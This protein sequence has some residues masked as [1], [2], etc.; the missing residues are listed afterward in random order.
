MAVCHSRGGNGGTAL[1]SA[2]RSYRS[3]VVRF[4]LEHGADVNARTHDGLTALH[5]AAGETPSLPERQAECVRLLLEAGAN[6][7][8]ASASGETPLMAAAW[9]GCTPSVQVLVDRGAYAGTLDAQGRT[10]KDLANARGHQDV[11]RILDARSTACPEL[12]EAAVGD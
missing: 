3:E 5:T 8:A 10:A 7:D 2:A 4:L 9:F 12:P 1:M 6:P 11:V